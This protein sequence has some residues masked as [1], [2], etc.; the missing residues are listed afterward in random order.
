MPGLE[1]GLTEQRRL[2]VAGDAG[3]R[4]ACA[5]ERLRRSSPRRAPTRRGSR[6]RALGHA[7]QLAAARRPSRARGCRRASCATRWTRSVACA[8]GELEDE[9][10]VDRAEPHA[11]A[12]RSRRPSTFSSSHS[13]FVAEKY[14]SSTRPVRSRTSPRGPP[15]AA[16]RSAPR[17]GGPARRSRGAAARRCARSQATTVSRWFVMP[18]A[19]RSRGVDAGGGE[20]LAARPRASPPRSRRRR[21]RP[22]PG[23]GKCCVE[24][25]VGA[26]GELAPR[27]RR[28]GSGAGRALVD[29]EDHRRVS[30]P[31]ASPRQV[32]AQRSRAAGGRGAAKPAER[33]PVARCSR[34]S[35]TSSSPQPGADRVDRHAGL[36]AEAGGERQHGARAPA[37]RIAR[38]PEIGAS[39]LEAA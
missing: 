12:A 11:V 8:A 25:A 22:S 26:A 23:C 15:R 28:R 36:H 31:G 32:H 17:C 21:A 35:S 37:P 2:L 10:G 5:A 7:E 14:G 24:L 20:R 30:L 4:H 34:S 29:R 19:A 27:R 18:I 39:R 13:I 16:R 9:P 3:D 6:Q 1:A 33:P 38:W